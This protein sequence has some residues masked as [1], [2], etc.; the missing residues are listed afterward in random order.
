V[1]VLLVNLERCEKMRLAHPPLPRPTS[2]LVPT[3]L[4]SL[5]GAFRARAAVVFGNTIRLS[6]ARDRDG[7]GRDERE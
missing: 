6:D 4:T 3:L 1:V 2:V 7:S 5:A